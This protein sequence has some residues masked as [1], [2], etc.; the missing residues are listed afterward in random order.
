V[1]AIPTLANARVHSEYLFV[2]VHAYGPHTEGDA[3]DHA[4]LARHALMG[5]I[6]KT[7]VVDLICQVEDVSILEK[8][9]QKRTWNDPG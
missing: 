2:V 8:L 7:L 4:T 5:H 9:I 6:D 3:N 1:A